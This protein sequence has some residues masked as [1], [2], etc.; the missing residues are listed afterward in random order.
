VNADRVARLK[1][2]D[3]FPQL[4]LFNLIQSVHF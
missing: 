1:L 2:R 3:I 4:T